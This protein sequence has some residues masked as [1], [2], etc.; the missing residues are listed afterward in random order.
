[1]NF[2]LTFPVQ[3]ELCPDDSYR[4]YREIEPSALALE[5]HRNFKSETTQSASK[6]PCNYC[7]GETHETERCIKNHARTHQTT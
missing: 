4:E 3:D 6:S 1:M 5:N 7:G 2:V